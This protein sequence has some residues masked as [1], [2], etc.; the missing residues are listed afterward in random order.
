MPLVSNSL[1]YP[2]YPTPGQGLQQAANGL[3]QTV[4]GLG[5]ALGS[6]ARDVRAATTAPAYGYQQPT[7]GYQQPAWGYQQPVQ[8]Y[9]A[10]PTYPGYPAQDDGLT[11]GRGLAWAGGAYGAFSLAA[12][13]FSRRPEGIMVLAVLAAGAWVGNQVYDWLKSKQIL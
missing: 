6:I 10:Y 9:P 8:P 12:N 13:T 7:Y 4:D 5:S 3:V 2:S 11:L 1:G